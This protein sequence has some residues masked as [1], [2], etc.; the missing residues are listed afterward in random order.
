MDELDDMDLGDTTE[1]D[2]PQIH[3]ERWVA[4]LKNE[5]C[6]EV[7]KFARTL[8]EIRGDTQANNLFQAIIVALREIKETGAELTAGNVKTIPE[9]RQAMIQLMAARDVQIQRWA[10]YKGLAAD[11]AIADQKVAVSAMGTFGH[12]AGAPAGAAHSMAV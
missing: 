4:T 10:A 3:L 12:V 7:L 9:A 6:S 1:A 11:E 2:G 5:S 8:E